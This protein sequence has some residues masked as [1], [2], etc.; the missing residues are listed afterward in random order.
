MRTHEEKA[1]IS[2]NET[3]NIYDETDST[4]KEAKSITSSKI[5]FRDDRNYLNDEIVRM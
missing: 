2:K 3:L 1:E 5:K 4:S